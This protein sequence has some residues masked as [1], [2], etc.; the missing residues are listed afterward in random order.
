MPL[1]KKQVADFEAV[2]TP[3]H[4]MEIEHSDVAGFLNGLLQTS[5]YEVFQLIDGQ[6]WM[7]V[8]LRLKTKQAPEKDVK[9]GKPVEI[10]LPKEVVSATKTE[11]IPNPGK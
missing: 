11:T 2:K 9:S 6:I 3:W 1:S 5:K 10:K 8:I 4:I 7:K